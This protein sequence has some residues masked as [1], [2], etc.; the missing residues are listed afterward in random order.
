LL[1]DGL[2][3]RL[4]LIP[5]LRR[6]MLRAFAGVKTSLFASADP[7]ALAASRRAD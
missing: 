6:E 7:R 2:F 5:Y 1:R 4:K 3:D